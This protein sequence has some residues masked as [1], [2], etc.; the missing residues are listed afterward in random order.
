MWPEQKVSRAP[1]DQNLSTKRT[2]QPTSQTVQSSPFEIH[3]LLHRPLSSAAA[4]W[5]ARRASTHRLL[6]LSREFHSRLLRLHAF[7]PRQP[8]PKT[9]RKLLLVDR[10]EPEMK[11]RVE[12]GLR[13]RERV[14][15]GLD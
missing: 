7:Y 6:D 12:E 14:R 2:V 3:H 9:G 8:L 11:Q 13:D 4:R 10:G 5:D 15:E 1:R